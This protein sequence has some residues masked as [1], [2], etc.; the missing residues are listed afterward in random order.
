MAASFGRQPH[1]PHEVLMFKTALPSPTWL[2]MALCA[3]VVLTQSLGCKPEFTD[4]QCK[5]DTDC[6]VGEVCGSA[7]VCIKA[8][9]VVTPVINSF[10]ADKTTITAGESVTLSWS[11]TDAA[12]A[13]ITGP[14]DTTFVIPAGELGQGMTQVSPTQTATYTLTATQ[15]SASVTRKVTITV[16]QPQAPTI[17]SFTAV[18]LV[19]DAGGMV[20]LSWQ[21]SDAMSGTITGGARPYEIPS[22]EL[23]QGSTQVRVDAPT[24]FTLTITN[25]AGEDTATVSVGVNGQPPVINSFSATPAVVVEGE[26]VVLSWQTAGAAS[27]T[28]TDTAANQLDLTGLNPM[29][30][31]ITLT[32]TRSVTYTL[33][34]TN[35]FGAVPRSV[36]V[37][38]L[39]KLTIDSF[40]ADP[41]TVTVGLP[42]TLAWQ[43][44]GAPA[45]IEIRDAAGNAIDLTGASLDNGSVQVSP[46]ETTTYTLTARDAEQEVS[47][48][49]TITVLPLPPTIS[50]FQADVAQTT[51]GGTVT[52]SWVIDGATGLMLADA[53]GNMIDV[54]GKNPLTDFVVVNPQVSTTYTLTATNAGGVD[55]ADVTIT[56][57]APVTIN[58]FTATP[59]S[60]L[61][62]EPITLS[63]DVSGAISLTIT[64]S[65]GAP[66]DLTGKSLMQDTLSVVPS[67]GMITYTLIADGFAGPVTA[68]ATVNVTAGVAISDFSAT[69]NPVEQGQSVTLSWSTVSATALT[70]TATTA[71]GSTPVSL[72]GKSIASDTITLTPTETTTYTLVADG[73]MGAQVTSDV[74]VT[75]YVAADV[76]SFTASPNTTVSGQPV[77][78]SWQTVGATSLTI[79]D[80]FGQPLALPMGVDMAN[81]SIVVRPQRSV[82]YTLIVGGAN[83]TSDAASAAIT[84][85][86]A[87]LLITEVHSNP[88]GTDDGKEW[89]EIYNP[90]D[91]FVDL[92]NYSLGTGGTDYLYASIQLAGLLPPKGCAVIGGP[93]SSADNGSPVFFQSVDWNANRAM[94]GTGG[95]IQ[96]GGADADGVALF[97]VPKASLTATTVPMDAVLFGTA[98]TNNLLGEDGLPKSALSPNPASGGSI[99]R[100]SPVSDIFRAAAVPTPGRCFTVD[101]LQGTTRAPNEAAGVLRF[102][103]FGFDAALMDVTLGAQVLTCAASAPGA[104]ECALPAPGRAVTGAQAL[105]ITQN[106][107]YTADMS[108]APVVTALMTPVSLTRANAFFWEG[109]LDDMS[110]DLFCGLFAPGAPG[111]APGSPISVSGE[112]YIAGVTNMGTGELPMGYVV[113][114]AYFPRGQ[115]PYQRFG[116]QWE[117]AVQTATFGGPFNSN[118]IYEATF[119]SAT[120]QQAEVA[121]RFSPDG[122]SYYYCDLS[123]QGGSDDGWT[124]HGGAQIEWQ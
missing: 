108:G 63:W 36:D 104:Y 106:R 35:P 117:T 120:A 53:Q 95:G 121:L 84:V 18:P 11:L 48:T 55:T 107:A 113:E 89:V 33:T 44:R 4:D 115:T 6:F 52:L 118:V 5:S 83:N 98:N 23:G 1:L 12:S 42:S 31:S 91:T 34:A 77:T 70:L 24:T 99:E 27:I 110:N 72:A 30:D 50:S 122:V 93:T 37:T 109:R 123:T 73:A 76:I 119:T 19:V 32:P 15:G 3:F 13:T 81:D 59:A 88:V 94:A 25:V 105:T 79:I 92:A 124:V 16:N 26:Q 66:V 21:T 10:T 2:A 47:A 87:Q 100:I 14:D 54:S 69:P 101:Q 64:A 65:S 86:P 96:N 39:P 9:P 43:I 22:G 97:A 28:I 62:G 103:G 112:I 60:V 82:S 38:V 78:L 116:Q 51:A 49:A 17:T 111:A 85:S 102:T 20:T 58:S 8:P 45:G 7:G 57:G 46:A 74:T 41:A 90:G 56:V 67:T 68:T 114:G 75:V 71:G 40:T 29:A 80:Q 61:A